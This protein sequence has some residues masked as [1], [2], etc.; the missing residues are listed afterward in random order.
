MSS[1]KKAADCEVGF[2]LVSVRLR[3]FLF[4]G[5]N[6]FYTKYQHALR[7]LLHFEIRSNDD[8]LKNAKIEL[9]NSIF[10]KIIRHFLKNQI[11]CC[12]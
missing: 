5:L 11:S 6:F 7:T 2:M 1:C 8:S 10:N 9:S 12:Y 3:S 4:D